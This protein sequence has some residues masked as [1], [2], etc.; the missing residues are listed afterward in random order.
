M[1]AYVT[2]AKAA[3]FAGQAALTAAGLIQARG[4]H[5]T[6]V[7]LQHK[8]ERTT[9]KLHMHGIINETRHFVE[10]FVQAEAVHAQAL[11][12]GKQQHS[13]SM[14]AARRCE[15]R[16]GMRDALSNATT[17]VNTVL[18]CDTVLLGCTFGPVSYTHLTL[19]T[20]YSV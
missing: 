3:E 6:D 10:A 1:A 20:I 8:A 15:Q 13:E 4:H 17:R 16:E 19:P 14:A 11:A 9:Q 2:G 5:D 7:D 18:V 12:Q